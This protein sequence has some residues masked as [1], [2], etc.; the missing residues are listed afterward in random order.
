M[1]RVVSVSNEPSDAPPGFAEL[2][3]ELARF[4]GAQSDLSSLSDALN[5]IRASVEA[6]GGPPDRESVWADV[7][8]RMGFDDNA[9]Q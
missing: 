6:E 1:D 7:C 2:L 5:A 9:S 4:D 3:A 8:R